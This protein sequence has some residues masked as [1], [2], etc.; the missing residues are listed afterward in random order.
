MVAAPPRAPRGYS[1]G[2]GRGDAAAAAWIFRGDQAGPERRARHERRYNAAS[3]E[4]FDALAQALRDATGGAAT[5]LEKGSIDEAFVELA[6]PPR[7]AKAF[8]RRVKR[9]VEAGAGNQTSR[10]LRARSVERAC[11]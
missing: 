8:C 4:F 11:S 2:T 10:Y 3:R 7:D 6:A 5:K 9:A 1:V